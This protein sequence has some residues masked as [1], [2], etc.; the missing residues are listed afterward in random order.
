VGFQS[1]IQFLD[2]NQYHQNQLHQQQQA[3]QPVNDTRSVW[4]E[5]E[6]VLGDAMDRPD[7]KA[8]RISQ[9]CCGPIVG[10]RGDTFPEK[11][12]RL[13]SNEFEYFFRV[14]SAQPQP[15]CG[16]IDFQNSNSSA[17]QAHAHAQAQALAHHHS[18]S[19]G[20][21]TVIVVKRA[22]MKLCT[23]ETIK[24]ISDAAISN[25]F[26]I[27]PEDNANVN[28]GNSSLTGHNSHGS[29]TTA[30]SLLQ[31]V[32][33]QVTS[34]MAHQYPDYAVQ[35]RESRDQF[36]NPNPNP[37]PS[38][39]NKGK[40]NKDSGESDSSEPTI[41]SKSIR[42]AVSRHTSLITTCHQMFRQDFSF[43]LP[44][45]GGVQVLECFLSLCRWLLDRMSP[46]CRAVCVAPSTF[47]VRQVWTHFV[48]IYGTEGSSA[49]ASAAPAA[50]AAVAAVAAVPSSDPAT[51][52]GVGTGS[53]PIDKTTAASGGDSVSVFESTSVDD[54]SASAGVAVA[55]GVA[56]SRRKSFTGVK[57]HHQHRP[58]L[59]GTDVTVSGGVTASL[60]A[61]KE[62]FVSFIGQLFEAQALLE[63]FAYVNGF[64]DGW[65]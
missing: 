43:G 15:H 18:S 5:D 56:G 16:I 8:L 34:Q 21:P 23:Q 20:E 44:S 27:Y 41:L 55:A 36:P 63:H 54:K 48:Q 46:S 35:H 58:L 39:S 25:T 28:S 52:P 10:V 53:D 3:S 37:N 42:L 64:L 6:S 33:H 51:T 40:G 57:S 49:I 24:A 4:S 29:H 12:V 45:H 2:K 31:A 22:R 1:V 30:P 59:V 14:K 47:T 26:N 32:W 11:E 61:D 38:N 19:S 17:V 65:E 62:Y 13:S 9:M 50:P 7:T 60:C